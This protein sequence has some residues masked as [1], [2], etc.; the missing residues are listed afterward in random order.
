M[1]QFKSFDA[2]RLLVTGGDGFVGTTFRAAFGGRP[3]NDVDGTVE[4]RDS[5]RLQRAIAQ[6]QPEAVLHLAA[7]SSVAA[8]FED[9]FETIEINFLGTLNL[10]QALRAAKFR[11]VFVY[12]GSAD[13][14]GA[15]EPGVPT[16]EDHPLRPRSPYAVSKVAAEALCYQWSQTEEFR[17]V[18]ARPFNQIGPG[19]NP[20]FA[21]PN[22]ARQV[23]EIKY[24][25]SAPVLVT[26]DLDV[27]RDFTDVRDTVRAY[28][29]LLEDGKDGE[30]YNICSGQER[31]IRSLVEG[32]LSAAGVTA[33]FQVDPA[34][35]RPNEQRS[36]LGDRSK[37]ESQLGWAPGI[38]LSQTLSDI[39]RERDQ[40]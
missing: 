38:S 19:Q 28:A 39:L 2:E 22:F 16:R 10:L 1:K 14:Y 8:S 36:M 25:R 11:G 26:G 29:A 30:V 24:G 12:V 18:L 3:L 13:V 37:V 15:V 23:I 5:A 32:M 34:R 9:P 7:Q 35:V 21:I 6:E 40:D 31:S 27:K 20:R 17:I 4:L 33:E